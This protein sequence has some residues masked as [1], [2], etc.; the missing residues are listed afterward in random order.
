M[1]RVRCIM[2]HH[3]TLDNAQLVTELTKLIYVQGGN[4]WHHSTSAGL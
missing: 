3:S 2:W 4:G 1:Y